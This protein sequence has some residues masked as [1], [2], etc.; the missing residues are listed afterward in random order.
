LQEVFR[1]LMG[2]KPMMLASRGKK[3]L[4][5]MPTNVRE[6]FQQDSDGTDEDADMQQPSSYWI[7]ADERLPVVAVRLNER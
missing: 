3:S 4:V 5:G 2:A 7:V 6:F 1:T